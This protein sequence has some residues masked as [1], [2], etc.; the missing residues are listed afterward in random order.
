[1]LLHYPIPISLYVHIPWCIR[2]CPYCD[3]N[4]HALKANNAPETDYINALIADFKHQRPLMQKRLFKTIFIGGGTPSLFSA[5]SYKK[6]LDVLAEEEVIDEKAEITL[7]VNPGSLEH[8]HFE[9]YREIGINRLSI[10]IQSFQDEKLKILHRIHSADEAYQ[11]VLAAKKA[12]FHNFNI[13]LM[14]GL[15]HQSIDDGIYDLTTALSLEPTHLSWYQLTIEPHTDFFHHPPPLPDEEPLLALQNKGKSLLKKQGFYHYEISAF[16]K[17]SRQ[18]QHNLNYWEFGDYMGIGA[19]AHGKIT[20]FS[21]QQILRRWNKKHPKDYLQTKQSALAEQS[22]IAIEDLPLEFMM[23]ALRLY[24]K[25][26]FRYFESR[27]GL[28]K[29]ILN[30]WLEEAKKQGLL[31]VKTHSLRPTARGYRYLNELLALF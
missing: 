15:P 10:G 11:A 8:D 2:K 1:M 18:S 29:N 31:R 24:K 3:F 17:S 27:T 5:S 21:Q 26:T 4:S 30:P 16:A 20:Q 28:Q 23:N 7:E 19:G 13:D 6:L 22:V 12:G 9:H 14:F 25:T